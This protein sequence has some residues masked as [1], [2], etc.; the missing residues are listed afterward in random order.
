MVGFW[1]EVLWLMKKKT[2]VERLKE[3]LKMMGRKA[4]DPWGFVFFSKGVWAISLTRG[5]KERICYGWKS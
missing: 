2:G 1:K 5:G 3:S 4:E